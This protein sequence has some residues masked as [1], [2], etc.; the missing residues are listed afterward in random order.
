MAEAFDPARRG[1]LRKGI[2]GG[3]LLAIAGLAGVFRWSGRG[4][5]GAPRGPLRL[6]TPEEHATFA[7]LAEAIVPGEGAAVLA[8]AG[9]GTSWPSATDVDC[10]GKADALLA[11]CHPSIGRDFRRLLGLFES[12]AFGLVVHGRP[13]RCSRLGA[14][15]RAAR[16][17][18]WRRSRLTLLRTG[19]LALTRLAHATYYSSPEVYP[20]IGY[21]GPPEVA[22]P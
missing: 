12:A 9:S 13:T 7:A 10:A 22:R 17:S 5:V 11:A 21:P 3:A 15:G 19:A 6:L 8:G 20:A 16:L 14:A 4:G 18:A 2:A 1:L